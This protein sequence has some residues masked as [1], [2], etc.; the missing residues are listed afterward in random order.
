MIKLSHCVFCKWKCNSNLRPTA[1]TAMRKLLKCT[2][3]FLSVQRRQN[4]NYR[5]CILEQTVHDQCSLYIVVAFIRMLICINSDLIQVVCMMAPLACQKHNTCLVFEIQTRV[6]QSPRHPHPTTSGFAGSWIRL[7]DWSHILLHDRYDLVFR[8]LITF[9][10]GL[11]KRYIY[12]KNT[13]NILIHLS[14]KECPTLKSA[15]LQE[16]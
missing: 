12:Y 9:A 5:N 4:H 10:K 15:K 1:I 6:T 13:I 2:T 16:P 14:L 11:T 8:W 3:C 7:I